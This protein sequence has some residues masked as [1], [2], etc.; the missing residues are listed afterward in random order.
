MKLPNSLN[1]YLNEINIKTKGPY[2]PFAFPSRELSIGENIYPHTWGNSIN[3]LGC[4][5]LP[6]YGAIRHFVEVNIHKEHILNII[7]NI[8]CQEYLTSF[9]KKNILISIKHGKI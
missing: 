8:D 1:H 7:F 9:F 5:L 2:G 4:K 3:P 6:I